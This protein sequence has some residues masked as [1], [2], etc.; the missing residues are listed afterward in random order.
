[1][2]RVVSVLLCL[3]LCASL[4]SA[5]GKDYSSANSTVYVLKNGKVVCVDVEDFDESVYSVADLQ[6]YAEEKI[7]LYNSENGKDA[8]KLQ[9]VTCENSRVSM[10]IEYKT[11]EDFTKFTGVNL[12]V[13]SIAEALAAGYDFSG[14]FYQVGEEGSRDTSVSSASFVSDSSYKVA[15]IDSAYCVNVYGE[16]AFYSG[17][18][19]TMVDKSTLGFGLRSQ[20]FEVETP[21]TETESEI[22]SE[23]EESQAIPEVDIESDGS[24]GEDEWD[25]SESTEEPMKEFV[26]EEDDEVDRPVTESIGSAIIIFK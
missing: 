21:V 1:M 4:F 7:N 6:T 10:M 13:G 17:K 23:A 5:C 11:V 15:I 14:D 18:Y 8:A 25:F 9:S 24:V 12:F 22:E 26:F 16:I 20:A 3:I 2:K 19:T